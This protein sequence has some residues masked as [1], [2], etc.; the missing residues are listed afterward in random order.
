MSRIG[1]MA[2]L[3]MG[4]ATWG[5][6]VEQSAIEKEVVMSRLEPEL[7]SLPERLS[8]IVKSLTLDQVQVLSK[9][10]ET[11]GTG[12]DTVLDKTSLPQKAK[13]ELKL[14]LKEDPGA[15]GKLA[16]VGRRTQEIA[17]DPA[18][19]EE[20][21]RTADFLN[22]NFATGLA[23]SIDVAGRKRVEK[24]KMVGGPPGVVRVEKAREAIPRIM[25]E[26]H[27]YIWRT[28]RRIAYGPFVAVM[29]SENEALGALGIGM[30][31]GFRSDKDS[32]S[33]LNIG[34]GVLWDSNVRF[35]GSG[36]HKGEPLPLGETE[37]RYEEGSKRCLLLM[38][39][40]RF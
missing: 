7:V 33:S 15:V 19:A 34:A 3:L 35:L 12:I 1:G 18:T 17:K 24:A 21:K 27:Q 16:A 11:G 2:C 40:F 22:S 28:E 23:L 38:I 5:C 25:L 32:T 8:A 31:A 30:M 14:I 4:F 10:C 13:D 37:V 29:N 9:A 20:G 36:V 26:A 6:V 39:S